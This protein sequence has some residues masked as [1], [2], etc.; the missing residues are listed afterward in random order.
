MRVILA[1]SIKSHV[2]GIVRQVV[3]IRLWEGC[4]DKRVQDV[5]QPSRVTVPVM[6]LLMTLQL[7]TNPFELVCKPLA[8]KIK[9]ACMI[10]AEEPRVVRR[11]PA[12]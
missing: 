4:S 1:R 10:A 11:V 8:Q 7:M 3:C 9:E 5:R 6:L 12:R 2:A